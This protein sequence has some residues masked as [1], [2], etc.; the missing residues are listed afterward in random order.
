M[1]WN[2]PALV[3]PSLKKTLNGLMSANR[4]KRLAREYFRLHQ[5]ELPDMDFVLLV[6]KGVSELSNREITEALGKL[7]RRHSRLAH[8]S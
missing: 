3:L 8:A 1:S 5:H 2:I 7:W 4:I 6:R